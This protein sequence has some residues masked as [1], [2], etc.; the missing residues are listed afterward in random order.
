[1]LELAST[2]LVAGACHNAQGMRRAA[3]LAALVLL[4]ARTAAAAVLDDW[5][6][7][8]C[9]TVIPPDDG[10]APQRYPLLVALHG[11]GGGVRSLVRAWKGAAAAAGV[12][13]LA[14]RCP[15]SL[16]CAAGSFWQWYETAGHDPTWLG[17]QI[18]AV[19]ARFPVDAQR[20]YATGYSG[21]A[22]YL[23]WY[24]PTHA[25][26]FAA[27]AHVAGGAP[28]RPPC[29]ACKLPVLFVL[30]APD[31]MLGPYTRPLRDWY[32][33]CGG[34]E[35]SWETLP[36]VT[37]EGILQVLEAG[38][39]RQIL[40]WLLAHPAACAAGAPVDAG[41][42]AAVGEAGPRLGEAEEDGGAPP[43]R[44]PLEPGS[45]P[46]PRVPPAAVGCACG[47]GK[48][49]S[50]AGVGAGALVAVGLLAG[51]LTALQGRRRRRW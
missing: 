24:A 7:P 38:R 46:P 28:Y 44:P 10:G 9:V 42:A 36:G 19:A 40:A 39:A 41:A 27:V 4:P 37:H 13:L 17:A 25:T 8:G 2:H 43:A 1:L 12:I 29:P 11:D 50:G 20:L 31:P 47:P 5:P 51:L 6:C 23:G 35:I 16:G 22:T 26:R 33:S 48:T 49:P 14:P 15:R 18:D 30:G 32:E 45:A 21:G 34:H 3:A